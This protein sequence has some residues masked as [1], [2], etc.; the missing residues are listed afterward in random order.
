MEKPDYIIFINKEA[1]NLLKRGKVIR[2]LILDPNYGGIF[3]LNEEVSEDFVMRMIKRGC[4]PASIFIAY[5]YGDEYDLVS[6]VKIAE[7]QHKIEDHLN[8]CECCQTLFSMFKKS[9]HKR[10]S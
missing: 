10:C 6:G 3:F 4:P 9:A 5:F 8:K 1:Q 7:I 2:K